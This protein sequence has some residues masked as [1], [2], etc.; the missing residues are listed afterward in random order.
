MFPSEIVLCLTYITHLRDKEEKSG[1]AMIIR[2]CGCSGVVKD[3][4]VP[5]RLHG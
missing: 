3:P 1:V 4:E 2:E 5:I